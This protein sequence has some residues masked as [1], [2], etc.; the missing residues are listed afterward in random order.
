MMAMILGY[1][2]IS[3]KTTN[4]QAMSTNKFH[5][6]ALS[7]IGFCCVACATDITDPQAHYLIGY[8]AGDFV[9]KL[10]VDL[11]GDGQMDFLFTYAEASPDPTTRISDEQAGGSLSWEVYIAKA[12]GGFT[13]STGVEEAGEGQ[14]TQG[15]GPSLNPNQLCVGTI[16][17][18]SRFGIIT[19]AVKRSKLE[20]STII[21]AYTWEG[22]HFKQW[23]LAEYVAGEQNAIFDKY[24]KEDKR[25][26]VALQQIKP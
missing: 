23:R 3:K 8:N 7:L 21:Y 26:H 18:I 19:S 24:L 5:F 9:K 1:G 14:V 12:S 10:A 16:S 17:E 25:T 4:R 11:N 20:N 13:L 6:I 22:D 15:A 2:P